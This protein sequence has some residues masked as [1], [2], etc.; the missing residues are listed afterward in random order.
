MYERLGSS[1][2]AGDSYASSPQNCFAD[3]YLCHVVVD[4]QD[5]RHETTFRHRCAQARLLMFAE[6]GF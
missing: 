5:L 2:G 4:E 6:P 3:L 1:A